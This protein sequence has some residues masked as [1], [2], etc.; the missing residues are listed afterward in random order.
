MLASS[1]S[2]G[3][4]ATTSSL[5]ISSAG[6]AGSGPSSPSWRDSEGSASPSPTLSGSRDL[7]LSVGLRPQAAK[8]AEDVI[9]SASAPPPSWACPSDHPADSPQS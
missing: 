4:R 6:N 2:S 5:A 3:D 9:I 1:S 7:N 8:G